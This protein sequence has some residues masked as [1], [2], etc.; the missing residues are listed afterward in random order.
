M[1]L[2]YVT[3]IYKKKKNQQT[4]VLVRHINQDLTINANAGKELFEF[5]IHKQLCVCIYNICIHT[6]HFRKEVEEYL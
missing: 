4:S 2:I 6:F 1:C 5:F 3:L